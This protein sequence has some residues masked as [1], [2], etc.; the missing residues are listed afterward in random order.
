MH[1]LRDT[2]A[3]ILRF[4]QSGALLRKVMENAAVGMALIGIDR[5]L[6]YANHAFAEMVGEGVDDALGRDFDAFI[7]S[8]DDAAAVQQLGR[9]VVGEAEEYRGEIRLRHRDGAAI[10]V[11]ASASLLRSDNTG[12]PL[13]VILQVLNIDRQ[14]RAEAALAYSESRWNYALE[15]ARQGVWDHDIRRDDMFYSRMWR[16]MRGIGEHEYI[17][18][19]QSEWL[20]RVH[21]ED[22][23]RILARVNRQDAGEEGFD[24]LEY[25]ERHRDGHW[26]WILSRG[27]PV[28]WAP[29]GTP[30]RTVGTDTDIT[31]L[32]H[33]EAQLAD[34]KERLAVTLR[35]IGDGVISTDADGRV[36]FMNP[37]AEKLT[38]WGSDAA[39]GLPVQQVFDIVDEAGNA[40][41][42]SPV[43]TSLAR[44]E[45]SY[46][47]D[48][49]MLVGRDGSRRYI[50]SSAA[51]LHAVGGDTIG[52]VLVFQ[53]ITSSRTLQK[54]LAHSAT[55]DTLTGL[56]NRAAF[57]RAMQD[58]TSTPGA[59]A[60]HVLAFL[61]LDRFKAVNDGSGHAA[62]DALLQ[63]VAQVI[64]NGCRRNDIAARIG[65]DEFTLLLMDCPLGAA[66]RVVGKIAAEIAAIDFEWHGKR[67]EIG[68]SVG[69]TSFGTGRRGIA[70]LM[71]DADAACYDAKARGRGQV[72]VFDAE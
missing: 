14:K 50:R 25:R 1:S 7:H 58:V 6:L 69:M 62:G 30:L 37:I 72:A 34:E 17:D 22:V 36:T 11:M 31:H 64:R 52:A 9:L 45:V 28:E 42:A 33:V 20:K 49:I 18:P 29:D 2:T 3:P 38:G 44:D 21:P 53:D 68:A 12:R 60:R 56:P 46:L 41:S 57:E 5:R 47:D 23:P 65:G 39:I 43:S 55:H 13:Y 48:D 19:A 10:W 71:R 32:K 40:V 54:Q 35:S 27:K 4:D 51:P 26:I 70:A 15:S 16:A 67:Y 66:E 8:E 61:D 63:R 24:I 59:S